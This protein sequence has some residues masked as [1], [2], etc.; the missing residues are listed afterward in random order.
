MGTSWE[1]FVVEQI[2]QLKPTHLDM[3]FYRTHQGAEADVVL[4]KGM[5]PVACIE[6]K[7]STAP[8][9]SNGFYQTMSDLKTKK[10]FVLMPSGD[11]YN[12]NGIHICS[13]S[14]FINTHLSKLKH[15]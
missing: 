4:V 1:S 5:T 7:I 9:I 12:K 8:K 2:R 15:P 3:Y 6:I 11:S 14:N 13:V 10:N